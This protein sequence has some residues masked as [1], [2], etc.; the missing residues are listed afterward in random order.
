MMSNF[1][2]Q[3]HNPA[4]MP[5]MAPRQGAGRVAPGFGG[6]IGYVPGYQQ[7]TFGARMNRSGRMG[8]TSFG[9]AIPLQYMANDWRLPVNYVAQRI[10]RR[11]EGLGIHNS[12]DLI[13]R[14][15]TPF[16]RSLLAAMSAAFD[17]TVTKQL[18]GQWIN[19]WL[20][21]ADML[22]TGMQLDTARLLQRSG[23]NDV[24]S[25]ARYISPFDRLALYGTLT[26]NAIRFG[27]RMPSWGELSQACDAARALPYAI[28]W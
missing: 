16:K 9:P 13:R 7:D 12:Q 3:S 8:R 15:N 21:E 25:L 1:Q 5:L 17:K 27:Y 2:V 20:G 22:R 4:G 23:I 10:S 24:P 28:R 19:Y 26:T 11:L 18:A 6:G 14:A